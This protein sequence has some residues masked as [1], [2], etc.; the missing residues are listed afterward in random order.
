[1]GKWKRKQLD[2]TLPSL[3]NYKVQTFRS[4]ALKVNINDQE[5][6]KH[7]LNT[8]YYGIGKKIPEL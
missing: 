6:T 5:T 8:N 2:L 3:F 4:T 7:D 1:L